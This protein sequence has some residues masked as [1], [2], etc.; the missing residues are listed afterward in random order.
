MPSNPGMGRDTMLT[1]TGVMPTTIVTTG[2]GVISGTIV[3]SDTAIRAGIGTVKIG[4]GI[5]ALTSIGII[6]GIGAGEI[7]AVLRRN[8]RNGGGFLL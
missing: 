4:P 6:I 3:T 2:I 7:S 5:S 8:E 1:P